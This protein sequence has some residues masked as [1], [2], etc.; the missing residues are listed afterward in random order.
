MIIGRCSGAFGNPILRAS[1]GRPETRPSFALRRECCE[2][3]L[4]GS[5]MRDEWS[6]GL[7]GALLHV[8]TPGGSAELRILI[9]RPR[10]LPRNPQPDLELR[11]AGWPPMPVV[12]KIQDCQYNS[13]GCTLD[14]M[15]TS[16]HKSDTSDV[17]CHASHVHLGKINAR[18]SCQDNQH[19]RINAFRNLASFVFVIVFRCWFGWLPCRT[20][21]RTW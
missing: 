3:R 7:S 1:R 14:D 19:S 4:L 15:E 17:H 2:C 13:P 21:T 10:A 18:N 16:N 20:S 12:L 11:V 9:P 8:C 6:C 5:A